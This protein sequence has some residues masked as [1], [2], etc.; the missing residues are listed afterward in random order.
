M[1]TTYERKWETKQRGGRS[2]LD[3]TDRSY[4][5]IP[6]IHKPHWKWLII[7]YFFLGG[8]SGAS[9]TIA[10][11]ARLFE[12]SDNRR[13]IRAGYYISFAA[14]IPSPILLILDLG[15]PER[16]HHMLR[17]LKI[18][19]PMSVGSWILTVF[20]PFSFLSALMQAAHDGLL[21]HGTALTRFLRGLPARA[22]GAMGIVPGFSLAGYTGVLLAI[23][24]VP[25]WTKNYLLMGP[26]FLA[27]AVSNATAAITLSLSLTRGTS[28]RTLERLERLE[29]IALL[30]E[31]SLLFSNRARLDPVIARPLVEGRT[32]L[33]YRGGVLG[34]GMSVPLALHA[35]SVFLGKRSSRG[36]IVVASAL[37]LISGFLF[38]YVMVIAGRDSAD[39]P[40]AT[41]ELAKGSDL[42]REQIQIAET[43]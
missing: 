32:G 8:I 22:I 26:L 13:I 41:Y 35:K 18:R 7:V 17:I 3:E 39:D 27:S 37:T 40:K 25:L 14:L 24:A 15:R 29:V 42:T 10:S 12:D 2:A 11:I 5:D 4:Y 20:G 38:R 33:V 43:R 9:Y 36:T 16:F 6:V 19:S 34:L 1:S 28:H 31:M 21:G 30:A 23:T